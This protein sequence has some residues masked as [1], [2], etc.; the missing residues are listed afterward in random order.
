[1]EDSYKGTAIALMIELLAS[2]CGADFLTSNEII[3]M[4]IHHNTTPCGQFIVAID[5][6]QFKPQ[7]RM[8]RSFLNVTK[9]I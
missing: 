5:P 3:A 4:T 9:E 1:M 6:F 2:M 8:R 7:V